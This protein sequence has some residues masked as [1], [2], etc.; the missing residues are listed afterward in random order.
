MISKV[1]W[2]LNKYTSYEGPELCIV[3]VQN[4]FTKRII[5]WF[6]QYVSS[7]GFS[8]LWKLSEIQCTSFKG[9][10]S[11]S[12]W[13]SSTNRNPYPN[14]GISC[15]NNFEH[16]T[17]KTKRKKYLRNSSYSHLIIS[18]L[19]TNNWLYIAHVGNRTVDF[20]FQNDRT[21]NLHLIYLP[22]KVATQQE[23]W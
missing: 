16:L 9:K 2:L 22:N 3:L 10:K 7:S 6:I 17:P 14:F 15:W 4:R 8:Q 5:V 13:R 20:W 11:F 23:W 12:H 21:A 1:T 18:L 19:T